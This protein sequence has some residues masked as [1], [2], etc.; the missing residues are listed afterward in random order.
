[1]FT[2]FPKRTSCRTFL[3]H[4]GPLGFSA[5][6]SEERQSPRRKGV[7]G[8][9]PTCRGLAL[10]SGIAG[11]PPCASCLHTRPGPP[12]LLPHL[13]HMGFPKTRHLN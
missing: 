1:M 10:A 12:A 5:V 6:Q 11:S 9:R 13:T 4:L 8:P 2:A 3:G 7:R